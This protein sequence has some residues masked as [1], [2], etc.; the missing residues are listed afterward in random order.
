MRETSETIVGL[1]NQQRLLGGMLRSVA[2][3]KR[4]RCVDKPMWI[5]MLRA[6][7]MD[8]HA[9]NQ[10]IRLLSPLQFRTPWLQHPQVFLVNVKLSRQ[11]PG[12]DKEQFTNLY[13]TRRTINEN[14]VAAVG[15]S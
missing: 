14:L 4:P 11:V 6:A 1:K 3:G 7:G 8:Q 5:A 2:S 10:Q 9:M 12:V 15:T 13:P